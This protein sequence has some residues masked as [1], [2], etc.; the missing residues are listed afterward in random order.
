M[1]DIAHAFFDQRYVIQSWQRCKW[2]DDAIYFL[3]VSIVQ[4]IPGISPTGRYTT[5][6]PL[7]FVL[8]VTLVKD[9]YEDWK[10]RLADRVVNNSRTLVYRGKKWESIFWSD[11]VIGDLVAVS[12][13]ESFP[14][15]LVMIWSTEREG[16]CYIET[17]NLDGE[18]NLKLRKS[19][20]A[21]F[22]LFVHSTTD[23]ERQLPVPPQISGRIVCETPNNKLYHFDGYVERTE[24]GKLQPRVPLVSDNILLRGSQL[25]NTSTI[26]GIVV[27][28]GSDTKLVQNSI[29]KFYKSSRVDS[30]TNRQIFFV[31]LFQ[32]AL[33]IFLSIAFRIS[34]SVAEDHWY[35]TTSSSYNPDGD[36]A[37]SF[38]TFMILMNSLIPIS[39]YVMMEMVKLFQA[40]MINNDIMMFGDESGA[41]VRNSKLN[42]ELGQ[43]EYVFSDK[44]GT[45]TCNVM[46]FRRF[47][48]LSTDSATGVVTALSY[49]EKPKDELTGSFASRANKF[50]FED[51]R[52]SKGRWRQQQNKEEVRFLLQA[53]AVCNTVVPEKDERGTIAYQASSPDEGCLVR[54]AAVLG[55]E[56][57][58]RT[59]SSIIV[60]DGRE[61]QK[62]DILRVVEFSSARKRMSVVCRDPLGRL[63]LLTKGADSAIMDRLKC[64]N[65]VIGH[66]H[67]QTRSILSSFAAEGLRTL[68]FA[69]CDL[70]EEFYYRWRSNYDSVCTAIHERTEK[71]DA[72][73]DKIEKDLVLIGTTAIEDRLQDNVPQ[74]IELLSH[75]G[76][77]VWV[78]TGDKQ[79][80]AISIGYSCRL[81]HSAMG[82]F[83]F[84]DCDSSNIRHALEKYIVDVEAAAVESGQEIGLV[85][86]GS[87]L[88]SILPVKGDPHS[89][90]YEADLFVSLAT[91]CKAVLCCR[92]SPL[93][94]AQIV[95]AVKERVESVT[96]AIGDGANDVS[97]IQT[98]HVG[99]GITGFE[100]LQAARASDYSICYFEHLQRLLLVHGR[101]SYRRI[102]KLIVFSFYKNMSLYMT[103]FWFCMF[104]MFTGQTLHDSWAL[105]MYNL[106][107]TAFPIMVLAIFDRD[108]EAPRMLSKEQFPELYEDGI[109][110]RLFNTV[111][112]WKYTLTALM[113]SL[114]CF[115]IPLLCWDSLSEPDTGR[116]VG[117]S[118]FSISGYTTIL[119]VVTIKCGLETNTWTIINLAAVL[120][121]LYF[122]F[123]FLFLYC[124]MYEYIELEDFSAWYGADTRILRNPTYWLIVILVTVTSVLRDSW[125][126]FYVRSYNPQLFHCVQSFE[127][128]GVLFDRADVKKEAPWLF[129]KHEV[130][131]FKPTLSEGVGRHRFKR[132]V[133]ATDSTNTTIAQTSGYFQQDTTPGRRRT[134]I[135]EIIDAD[136]L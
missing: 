42:E 86:Q 67:D 37:V 97:M 110:N 50:T 17:A 35:L 103:Q 15:D 12:K 100:G 105:A 130:K 80:T 116:E 101:W 8:C 14:A 44:T 61:R 75:A 88:L 29:N 68:V 95:E 23:A 126:K 54:A 121:S 119:I 83:T 93:Q 46:E 5:L 25:R 26:Y 36:A 4:V 135:T 57:V 122:W 98:A 55:I 63:L 115:F 51:T 18:N 48:C 65:A 28:T 53:M 38:L 60:A 9:T 27:F 2:L 128:R 91:K 124:S 79:E 66:A 43:V 90:E 81:L 94:K 11:V 136:D 118:G 109:K 40:T 71:V 20:Q 84:D 34:S 107:F 16:S 13:G 72:A 41:S 33:S 45:L 69:T 49:G 111:E 62:W 76:A 125:Y 123:L 70:T 117:L 89:N 74:T 78:L 120:L 59:E 47:S 10:R 112:F 96:L 1:L 64:E 99:V 32:I 7:I 131:S 24:H 73:A 85:I 102:A 58:D 31:F 87:M 52:V 3:G 21:L 127:A 22:S 104:N 113:H 92:V 114:F 82:L 133:D 19:P 106:A 129:P 56:M 39:L 134:N 77:K 108:V 132:S 6:I 30:I